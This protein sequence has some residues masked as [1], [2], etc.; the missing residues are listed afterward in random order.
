MKIKSDYVYHP[1]SGS[2]VPGMVD[3][4]PYM[5]C[6][7]GELRGLL[8]E[9]EKK[10]EL[11]QEEKENL[12]KMRSALKQWERIYVYPEY[13]FKLAFA[14][15]LIANKLLKKAEISAPSINLNQYQ[16]M[17]VPEGYEG[18]LDSLSG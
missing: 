18:I 15:R 14:L 1:P 8:S 3:A 7:P 11:N 13:P 17:E 4:N 16:D 12:K 10:E 5:S 2:S 9:L 6:P